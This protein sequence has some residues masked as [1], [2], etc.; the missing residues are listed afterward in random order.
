M[1]TLK[2]ISLSVAVGAALMFGAC[3]GKSENEAKT[4]EAKEAA[5]AD[6]AKALTL[7]IQKENSEIKWFGHKPVGDHFGHISIKEGSLSLENGVLKSGKFTLDMSTITVEDMDDPKGNAKLQK[8]LTSEDFF[9]VEKHP[10]ATFEI[11]GV[12]MGSNDSA[13]IAGNLTIKGKTNNI[14][15]PAMVKISGETLEASAKFAIDRLKW[16]LHYHNDKSL[17]DKF[18][19][20]NID[21]EIRLKAA[22]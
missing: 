16:D 8:H 7:Q 4:G 18:I 9:L 5:T 14:E 3:K 19:Y 11:T 13:K 20:P 6:S 2:T 10:E 21:F 15:F 17:G 22:K 12:T 1:T